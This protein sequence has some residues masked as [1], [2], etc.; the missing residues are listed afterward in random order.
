MIIT[1]QGVESFKISQGNLVL[2]INPVSKD[3][4]YKSVNF[5]ADI[6]LISTNHPDMN[7]A[8]QTARGDKE[9]FIIKGPGEY[10]VKDISIK[11]LLSKSEYDGKELVNTI[12][13]IM[14]E[15]INLCFLGAVSDSALPT[16]TLGELGNIDILFV[17]IGGKGVLDPTSA[18]KLAVSLE[19]SVIIPMHFESGSQELKQFLKEGE[20][21]VEELDKL[22]IKKSDLDNKESEVIVLKEE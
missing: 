9:P 11:G 14:F 5:G 19:P 10:E 8:E 22:V 17:P 16:E 1:Y 4:K 18:Y 7:G 2:A 12:Y 20:G 13:K 3:S 6:T 21:D 15:N